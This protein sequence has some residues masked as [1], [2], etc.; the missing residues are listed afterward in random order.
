MPNDEHDKPITTK[1]LGQAFECVQL[2][3]TKS[4]SAWHEIWCG[5]C[6]QNTVNAGSGR[7]QHYMKGLDGLAR[8]YRAKHAEVCNR[9]RPGDGRFG[10]SELE[11]IMGKHRLTNSEMTELC[12]R[13][14]VIKAVREEI[15]SLGKRAAALPTNAG[16][17][18]DVD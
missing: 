17:V 7:A 1:Q 13:R 2:V 10:Q 9:N 12:M 11:R 8:H 18:K 5:E 3:Q 14:A 6:G 15:P 4:G 16:A